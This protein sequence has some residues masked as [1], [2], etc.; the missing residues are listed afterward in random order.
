MEGEFQIFGYSVKLLD[1]EARPSV[2]PI[3]ASDHPG[4]AEA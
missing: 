1:G 2:K 4:T 3:G